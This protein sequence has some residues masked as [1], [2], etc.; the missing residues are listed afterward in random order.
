MYGNCLVPKT[1]FVDN[2]IST[3]FKYLLAG[4]GHYAFL[5]A[6][7]K[8]GHSVVMKTGFRDTTNECLQLVYYNIGTSVG[9]TLE[10]KLMNENLVQATIERKSSLNREWR[11]V[12]IELPPGIHT[13]LIVRTRHDSIATGLALDDIY[14]GKCERKG[15]W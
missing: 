2:C 8:F 1:T 10:I 4:S 13:I 5:A 11:P 6:N 9:A 12:I 14:I 7:Q 15:K 3:L